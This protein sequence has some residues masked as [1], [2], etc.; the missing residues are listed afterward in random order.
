MPAGTGVCVV[1]M[2]PARTCSKAADGVRPASATSRRD[3]L[4]QQEAG[5]ALVH[6]EHVRLEPERGQG[7]DAAD[8]EQDLL[9]QAMLGVAAVEAVGD[10]TRLGRV[11]GQVRVEQEQADPPDLDP[12]HLRVHGDARDVDRDADRRAVGPRRERHRQ[13][14]GVQRRVVLLLQPAR[15]ERLPEVARAVEEADAGERH[16][17]VARRLEVVA[18]Q[19][20]EA[21]RVL[22]QHLGHAELGRE[23]R[24]R[25]TGPA[26]SAAWNQRGSDR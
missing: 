24:R 13:H 18:G 14:R 25:A 22:R 5:V 8:P 11:V 2:V 4:Q 9:P 21:A 26:P 17:E 23:V 7:A 19:H 3:A 15:R 6:V 1:K 12:P 10:D 16:A 20:A